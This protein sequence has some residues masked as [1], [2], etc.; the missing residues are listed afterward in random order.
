MIR[1]RHR[2]QPI[3]IGT[4]SLVDVLSNTVG[5]LALLCFIAGL[6]TG[7]LKWRLF[8]SEE[9][10]AATEPIVFVV[11]NG[12]IKHLDT[13]TLAA[14]ANAL[15]SGASDQRKRQSEH[16]L[17]THE[18]PFSVFTVVDGESAAW[19]LTSSLAHPGDSV[20]AMLVGRGSVA[21]QLAQL[22]HATSHI[23]LYVDKD[24]FR[25]YLDIVSYLKA[26]DLQVGWM[27]YE[28]P[29][30][31]VTGSSASGARGGMHVIDHGG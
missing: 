26:L 18:F 14:I 25:Y 6:E 13:E 3:S 5:A 1:R 11:H 12:R 20:E 22:D 23:Y 29:L 24:S 30:Q 16:R 10:V 21:A 19:T 15:L 31:L 27:P 8:I 28:E 2:L 7:N 4:D 17:A 9:T